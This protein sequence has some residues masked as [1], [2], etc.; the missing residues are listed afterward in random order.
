MLRAQLSEQFART[1]RADLLVPIDQYGE[2]SVLLEVE[3]LEHLDHVDDQRDALLIVRDAQPVRLVPVDAKR[4]LCE[5]A[6][7]V[8]RVHVREQ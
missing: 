8:H 4:L 7:Q 5:H 6:L 1:R 2:H 3:I